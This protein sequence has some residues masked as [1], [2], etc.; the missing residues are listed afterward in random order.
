[1]SRSK[2]L[3]RQEAA[4]H[5]DSHGRRARRVCPPCRNPAGNHRGLGAAA[6]AEAAHIHTR[7]G[8]I[9]AARRRRA[10]P[11]A[12]SRGNLRSGCISCI[13]FCSVP[14]AANMPW[15][16]RSR[17]RR[18][19]R[20]SGARR[21]MPASPAKPNAWRSTS[22]NHAAVIEFCK[23]HAVDLVVVGPET[24]LAAGIVDDLAAAGI[25]AFGPS[26]LAARLEGSKGFT[27]ALCTE[28][29]IPT[30]AYGRF[31]D[32]AAALAYVRASRRADRGQGRRA[33]GG[34]GRGGRSRPCAKPRTPST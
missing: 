17:P 21:A 28:F 14:A 29:G 33:G 32:A 2:G 18:W 5:G 8:R 15:R 4:D 11:W 30:G 1:M 12:L 10:K 6:V 20:N 9:V 24:P 7:S 25:K 27:K 31:S 34:Q 22:S 19:S 13:F 26:K 3:C 23:R 16:G